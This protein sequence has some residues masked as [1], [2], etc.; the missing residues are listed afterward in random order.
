M[1]TIQELAV[2]AVAVQSACNLS[3]VVYSFAA[4]LHELWEHASR[5][6]HG[7]DWVNQHP[8]TQAFVGKLVSLSCPQG[9]GDAYRQVMALAEQAA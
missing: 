3:G 6:G 4:V 8:I 5:G 1:R 9:E 7:T 2:E